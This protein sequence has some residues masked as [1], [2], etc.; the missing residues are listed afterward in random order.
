MDLSDLPKSASTFDCEEFCQHVKQYWQD[1]LYPNLVKWSNQI[2]VSSRDFLTQL[3][4]CFF[5][6][7]RPTRYHGTPYRYGTVPSHNPIRPIHDNT[8]IRVR[9]NSPSCHAV[10]DK[11]PIPTRNV[12]LVY[13]R[14]PYTPPTPIFTDVPV[15]SKEPTTASP[16]SKPTPR[17]RRSVVDLSKVSTEPVNLKITTNLSDTDSESDWE[18]IDSIL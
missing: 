11:Y 13:H 15:T 18:K 6:K 5:P 1:K 9:S 12:S 3:D 2:K 7:T 17:Y 10:E 4:D 14:E 8:P 16:V